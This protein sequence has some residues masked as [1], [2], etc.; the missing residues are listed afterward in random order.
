MKSRRSSRSV[1]TSRRHRR[2]SR[3]ESS[4]RTPPAVSLS[5][6]NVAA[7]ALQVAPETLVSSALAQFRFVK[8][9]VVVYIYKLE[10][11]VFCLC[12]SV[13]YFAVLSVA[14]KAICIFAV[15]IQ[16]FLL[17]VNKRRCEVLVDCITGMVFGTYLTMSWIEFALGN[18]NHVLA[19]HVHCVYS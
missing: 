17:Q 5:T 11:E 7:A 6:V 4:P 2:L 8:Q 13:Y 19:I 18:V 12:F 1:S 14:L 10:N 15:F 16:L 3:G 9:P